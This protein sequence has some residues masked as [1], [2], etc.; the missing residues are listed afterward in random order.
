MAYRFH[1]IKLGK[2]MYAESGKSFSCVLEELDPGE[3]Y[4]GTALE[5]LGTRI[6][7]SLSALISR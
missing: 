3:Q 1:T 5:G 4:R 2:G 7:A 6:S